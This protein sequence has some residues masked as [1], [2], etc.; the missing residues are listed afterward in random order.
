MINNKPINIGI[1]RNTSWG[2]LSNILQ[3]SFLLGFF[4]IIARKFSS[5]VFAQFLISSTVYQVVAA[6]S[7]LG[8]GQWFIR[9]YASESNKMAFTANFL[10]TQAYLGIVFYGINI[11][12]A[13]VLY[14]DPQ[15]RTL[16]LILGTNILFDNMISAIKTM[17]IAE[18]QQRKT[19]II[20][21]ADGFLKLLAACILFVYPIT[22]INLAIITIGTRL[23]SLGLFIK[24]G[25]SGMI[26]LKMLFQ[27][28]ISIND[29]KLQIYRNWR[30]IIIGSIS[31]I[32][33]R[34]GN[35]IIS[36]VLTLKDVA[37]YE[38]SFRILSVMLI[39]PVVAS[40]TIFPRFITL[41]KSN[42]LHNLKKF[43][44][45]C[46]LIYTGLSI[47][48]YV[49]IFCFA[50]L[51]MPLIF[52]SEYPNAVS[53]VKQ[54]FLTYLLFP[55][56]LLQANLLVAMGMEKLDMWFNILSFMVNIAASII[57]LYYIKD[58]AVINYSIFI[59]FIVFHL[60]Q[61][62][63]LLHK[64]ITGLNFSLAFYTILVITVF[65]L[66]YTNSL[67]NQYVVFGVIFILMAAASLVW[68]KYKILPEAI[69][70]TKL[71]GGQLL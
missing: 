10:R 41:F 12:F 69:Q 57:G 46:F 44:H 63:A 22:V 61:D 3:I 34:L 62:A 36:K 15:I 24:L 33:W 39:L 13:Y 23:F 47:L 20:L 38:I 49:F 50:D 16:C 48:A 65:G 9:Q 1:L 25:S 14:S 70:T 58:L 52:G 40:A 21:A 71:D 31:I 27:S 28:V 53:C 11:I 35:I 42:D 55:T 64:K 5:E 51:L 19:A 59:S 17:N 6:F 2:V 56:V 68:Y 18:N 43:Y 37:D 66:E 4:I 54:M 67:F 32:Y 60:L 30:F 45:S 7:S 26:N 29:I 8:L